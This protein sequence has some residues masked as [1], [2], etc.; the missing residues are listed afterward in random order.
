[1][2]FARTL[3]LITTAAAFV[4]GLWFL[5]GPAAAA[6][7]GPSGFRAGEVVTWLQH[8]GPAEAPATALRW[9][10][11]LL[12]W[13]LLV[14]TT[15]AVSARL[16]RFSPLIDAVDKVCISGIRRFASTIAGA[17]LTVATVASAAGAQTTTLPP[18]EPT[19][20]LVVE[21]TLPTSTTSG[22]TIR[23]TNPESAPRFRLITEQ[24]AA[25][26]SSLATNPQPSTNRLWTVQAGDHLWSIAEQVL[27]DNGSQ[28]ASLTD[29]ENYWQHL[30]GANRH[31]LPD[32]SNADLLYVGQSLL[33]PPIR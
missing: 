7:P 30:L 31:L 21:R 3:R 22:P 20:Q 18:A 23:Q 11:T 9:M 19:M 8:S 1:M 13:Y 17:S 28:Y 29:I 6:L 12:G 32:P 26:P 27:A 16:S 15:L 4:G 5:H 25:S 33:L 24:P 2:R 14:V 10:A